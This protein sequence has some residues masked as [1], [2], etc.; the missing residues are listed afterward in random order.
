[1]K[2][3]ILDLEMN[4]VPKDKTEIFNICHMEIIEYGAVAL[5]E[6]Y[7]EVAQFSTYVKPRFNDVIEERFVEMTGITTEMVQDAPEFEE[8]FGMFCR[9]CEGLQDEIEI[10]T[11]SNNDEMQIRK[12]MKQKH[13]EISDSE[14]K[15]LSVFR[16]FQ[17]DFCNLLGLNRVIALEKA[18]DLMGLDFQGKQHDAFHDARN[19]AEIFAICFDEKRD[20]SVLNRV[21]EALHPKKV[22]VSLGDM[23]DFSQFIEN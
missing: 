3:I 7:E 19:T 18:I 6:K 10:I 16:D 12:E 2:Y 5:N 4:A 20:K 9:W 11:W 8:A 17:R 21:K 23:I 1:M 13:Y 14:E 22:G 15:L